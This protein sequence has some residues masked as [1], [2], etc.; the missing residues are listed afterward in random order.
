LT[1][2]PE[3]TALVC[4]ND[5]VAVGALKACVELGTSVPDDVAVVGF[6]DIPLASLVMPSLTTC[7]IPRYKIGVKAVELLLEQVTNKSAE[8]AEVIFQPTLIPRKSA[9]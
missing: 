5:L 4:Y 2:R 3:I 7:H 6:D 8:T 9:P 1:T